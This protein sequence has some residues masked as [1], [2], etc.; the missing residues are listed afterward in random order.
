MEIANSE[1]NSKVEKTKKKVIFDIEEKNEA[2]KCGF[3]EYEG[4]NMSELK[5]HIKFEHNK[6]TECP[7]RFFSF[8]KLQVHLEEKHGI[9]RFVCSTCKKALPS[10]SALEEHC[11]EEKRKHK[12]EKREKVGRSF[13]CP[14]CQ[15]KFDSQYGV[16]KHVGGWGAGGVPGGAERGL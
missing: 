2:V 13:E 4:R 5:G 6:C 10:L 14:V 7:E 12:K 9:K 1:L 11:R 15:E 3:C 16:A 8:D